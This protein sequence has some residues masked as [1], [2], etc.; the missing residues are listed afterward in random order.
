M[1]EILCIQI[2]NDELKLSRKWEGNSFIIIKRENVNFIPI[3]VHKSHLYLS[4]LN[5]FNSNSGNTA[6]TINPNKNYNKSLLCHE[7]KLFS[8]NKQSEKLLKA[9]SISMF[10]NQTNSLSAFQLNKCEL[11][12]ILHIIVSFLLANGLV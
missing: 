4:C 12:L 10:L 8:L 7:I 1:L 5:V 9:S 3:I 2:L 11:K 6:N